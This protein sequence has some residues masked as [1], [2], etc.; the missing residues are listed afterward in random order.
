MPYLCTM[1]QRKHTFSAWLAV[2]FVLLLSFLPHHHHEGGAACWTSEVC[3]T[4]GRVN[5]EHTAHHHTDNHSH[6]CYWQKQNSVYGATQSALSHGH[7][8]A[9]LPFNF[10]GTKGELILDNRNTEAAFAVCRSFYVC[11]WGKPIWRRGP[12]AVC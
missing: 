7:N 6:E 12:P 5:D 11:P 8:L 9:F 3:H 4:D 10:W 1:N 2:A